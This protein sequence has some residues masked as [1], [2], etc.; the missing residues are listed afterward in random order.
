[1]SERTIARQ[2]FSADDDI[3]VAMTAVL[4]DPT[5]RATADLRI[6]VAEVLWGPVPTEFSAFVAFAQR[7]GASRSKSYEAAARWNREKPEPPAWPEHLG[8]TALYRLY[9]AADEVIYIGITDD[10]KGRM[11]WH[12]AN[13]TWW[14]E[15]T[16]RTVAFYP[17]WDA[18]DAAETLAIAAEKPIYNK[19]KQYAPLAAAEF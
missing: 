16:R 9:N 4:A 7:A 8:R 1:V 6:R 2:P 12:A 5:I 19:A 11:E 18:A 3:R 14:P 10:L 13:Q 15:V 17:D